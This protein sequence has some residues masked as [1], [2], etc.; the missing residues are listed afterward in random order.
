MAPI[1]DDEW[2]DLVAHE[3][4]KTSDPV[5]Q[6]YLESRRALVAEEQKHRSDHS[7]RQ[8]LSPI[9]KNACDIVSRIRD[10]ESRTATNEPTCRETAKSWQ[11]IRRLPK[12]ALLRAHCHSL[13]DIGHVLETAV[14]T[15]G[16]YISCPDGH[17][18]T[19][20][21]RRGGS[22]RIRFR[23][24][25]DSETCS[26]WADTYTRGTFTPLAKAAD[27]YP[28]GGKQG[29][30][31][32]LKGRCMV[33]QQD[34]DPREALEAYSGVSKLVSGMV[35]Y[36]PIWRTCLQRLMTNLVEDGI[37]WLELRLTFPLVYFREGSET[38]DSDYDHMFQAIGEEVAKFQASDPGRKFWGLRVIWS[39][40]RS[41][42]PRSIIED[43]DN[44]I[45][46]K[47][48][49]P[50][51]VAGYDLGGPESLGRSLADLLPEL[52]WFRKQCAL[53]GVQ[54]PFFLRAGEYL[55]DGDSDATDGNLF[56]SLLLGTR[57]LGNPSSLHKHPRLVEAIRDK[58]I[59]VE[60]PPVSNDGRGSTA[61]SST[62]NHPLPVLLT[63]GVS[64]TLSDDDSGV[65]SGQDQDVEPRMTNNFWRV[66]QAWNS[67]D[68]AT[69]GS[70]AE[71]SVRWAAFEDQDAETWA[72]DIRAASVG[73]G[74]KAARLQQWA[75][76]WERFCLWIVTEHGD[77]YGDGREGNP[78]APTE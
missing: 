39:T 74:V 75:V 34:R 59:L 1:T 44:C 64:C 11:I 6:N 37:Y 47:L 42:D 72:R 48:V 28:E 76:E 30:M 9:A 51:L 73:P 62:V 27:E 14:S 49:W 54:I 20:E 43:A 2:A 68:L 5:I 57:R 66:L 17:L 19:A 52:F 45:A 26:L 21:A 61:G 18:A 12:G 8:A 15:P 65:P 58:R 55:G 31:E 35:Y 7:F 13:V 40:M 29:F 23:G 4:P 24:K 33:P 60:T 78:D 71:N 67:T 53:E 36:E 3:L 56:D 25:A 69:L 16:M 41:Q 38:P 10:E 70:L 63:Q 32:W 22:L 77:A 46:T 50:R